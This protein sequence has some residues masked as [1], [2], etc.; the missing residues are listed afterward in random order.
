MVQHHVHGVGQVRARVHGLPGHSR[1]RRRAAL[2]QR[3]NRGVLHVPRGLVDEVS[4]VPL[5]RPLERR[6]EPARES[7]LALGGEAHGGGVARRAGP[8]GSGRARARARGARARRVV[9]RRARGSGRARQRSRLARGR[10]RHAG[11]REEKEHE[12]EPRGAGE[13]RRHRAAA[14]LPGSTRRFASWPE[15]IST[16]E[17]ASCWHGFSPKK[18]PITD[19]AHGGR[20]FSLPLQPVPR[21][22]RPSLTAHRTHPH[23]VV[24]VNDAF[25]CECPVEPRVRRRAVRVASP[26]APPNPPSAPLT[27]I[28]H[29]TAFLAHPRSA[30]SSSGASAWSTWPRTL[31]GKLVTIVDFVDMNRVRLLSSP[32]LGCRAAR[33]SPRASTENP[34]PPSSRPRAFSL[35]LSGRSL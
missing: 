30:T 14:R 28:T 23:A 20:L 21:E 5:A 4:R 7:R 26:R 33:R 34:K 17:L 9:Q 2:A 18:W 10:G 24:Y 12:R 13:G 27:E 3:D 31:Y 25:H 32:A 1:R 8:R 29:R 15:V 16:R 6:R 19:C 11:R 35:F 22:R